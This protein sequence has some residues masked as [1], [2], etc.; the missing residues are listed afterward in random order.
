MEQRPFRIHKR[1]YRI[2]FITELEE[3]LIAEQ[4]ELA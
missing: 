3:R 1:D 2:I 4:T